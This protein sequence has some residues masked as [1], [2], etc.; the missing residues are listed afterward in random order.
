[1]CYAVASQSSIPFGGLLACYTVSLP[2]SLPPEDLVAFVQARLTG[3]TPLYEEA[4]GIPRAAVL[5]PLLFKGGE[6]CVLFTQRS[7]EVATHKGHVSFPGGVIEAED[8][9]PWSAALRETEE[10]VGIR[11]A[12]VRHLGQLDDH[13]T[14]SRTFVITP[15]A[16]VVPDGAAHIRSNLEVARILEV[17]LAFLLDGANRE[18]DPRTGHWSYNWSE[19]PIWGATARI[20]TEFLSILAVEDP[21]SA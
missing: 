6:P 21:H 20:L 13:L 14:N 7:E 18:P 8:A 19:A 2:L 5:V 15:F 1:L 4:P 16:G 10:E 11:P 9:S 17:P 12:D 3:R